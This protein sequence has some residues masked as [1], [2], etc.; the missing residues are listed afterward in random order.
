MAISAVGA[1]ICLVLLWG[2]LVGNQALAGRPLLLLGV[3]LL[4]L[5]VQMISTGLLGEIII[6]F[7]ADRESPEVE[8]IDAEPD[9]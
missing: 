7:S 2:R 9:A 6:F 1:V 4:V 5:G 3:V 8:E